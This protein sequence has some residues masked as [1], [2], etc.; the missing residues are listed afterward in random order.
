M[1]GLGFI[2]AGSG[3]TPLP[4]GAPGTTTRLPAGFGVNNNL[5]ALQQSL[6]GLN[7]AYGYYSPYGYGGYGGGYQDVAPMGMDTLPPVD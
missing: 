3:I 6:F 7:G 1:L 4:V 2:P 5:F